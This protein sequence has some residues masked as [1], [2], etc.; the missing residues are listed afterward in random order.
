[1]ALPQ[2]R[3]PT[4]GKLNVCQHN[5]DHM[6]YVGALH[7]MMLEV[8]QLDVSCQAADALAH[9]HRL[10]AMHLDIKPGNFLRSATGIIKLAD[11]GLARMSQ[12]TLESR[13]AGGMMGTVQYMAPGVKYGRTGKYSNICMIFVQSLP[14]HRATEDS[15]IEHIVCLTQLF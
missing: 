12:T 7:H 8:L 6:A 2:T 3:S 14:P 5:L 9:L 1:M 4:T 13:T 15:L 10:P 11:F